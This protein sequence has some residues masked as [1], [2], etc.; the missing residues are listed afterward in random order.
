MNKLQKDVD[1]LE[2]MLMLILISDVV[3]LDKV[4]FVM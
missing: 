4:T 2:G 3:P 1:R